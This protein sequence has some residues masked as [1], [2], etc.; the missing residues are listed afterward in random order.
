MHGPDAEDRIS[1]RY[2]SGEDIDAYY[3]QR[4]AQ[5]LRAIVILMGDQPSG[6]LGLARHENHQRFFSEFR[7]A[8]RP[9]LRSLTVMRAVKCAQAMARESR[10]P[11]YAIAEETET[12]S[13][14]ILSR[15]GF[16]Q[17]HENIFKLE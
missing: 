3:G 2:A 6:V 7:E 13:R 5:T 4:P 16:V 14:R 10:L 11:V 1:W 12:D 8:L 9:H 17:Q 15:L